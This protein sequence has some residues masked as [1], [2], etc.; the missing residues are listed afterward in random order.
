ML[1]KHNEKTYLNALAQVRLN[2]EVTG[3]RTGI[4]TKSL[5][6]LNSKYD[7]ITGFPLLTSKKMAWKA[8]V[9]ELL[10]FIEGSTDERRLAEIHYGKPREELVG[11]QTIWT[12]N[13]DA[14]GKQLGYENNDLVKELGPV[15]GAQWAKQLDQ[16]IEEIKTNPNSRRLIM[17]SW[18]VDEIDQM[19]LP[20]CHTMCQFKVTPDEKLDLL[21]YQRSAD[22]FLGV[23]FNIASYSLFLMMVAQVVGLPHGSFHHVIGDAHIYLNHVDQVEE[24]LERKVHIPPSVYL[25]PEIKNI[26]NFTMDDITLVDYTSEDSI[27]APMAV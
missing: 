26:H 23:P 20:P 14:Q 21:M 12:A 6:G 5:F 27:K 18:N 11:K 25:N 10:W 2:G 1:T 7:L 4:G 22:M 3:D 19:A 15:Y 17:S 16:L 24:Q 8:I 9:S 13:A